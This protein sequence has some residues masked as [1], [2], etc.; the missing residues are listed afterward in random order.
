[1]HILARGGWQQRLRLMA[2]LI[3]FVFVLC[4]LLNHALGV[5]GLG[6]LEA[7]Q[8]WR[9]AF[10][11]YPAVSWLL[12]GAAFVHVSLGIL[13]TARRKTWKIKPWE[14]LQI[15]SGL[16]VPFIIS[17][18]VTHSRI[19]HELFDVNDAYQY[20]LFLIWPGSAWLQLALVLVVWMH[21]CI[22][23][24]FWLRLNNVYRKIFAPVLTFMIAVPVA[25]LSGFVAGGRDARFTVYDDETFQELKQKANWP[26]TE[27]RATLEWT[28]QLIEYT[29]VALIL[30]IVGY[31]LTSYII[32]QMRPRVNVAYNGGPE[33]RA[34]LGSTLLETS[35]LFGVPHASVCGGRARCSTCRVLVETG[36][37]ALA[38]PGPAE[39]DTLRSIGAPENVRLACQIRP[40]KPI[41]VSRLISPKVRP[42]AV[43]DMQEDKMEASGVE[44]SLAVMF[45]D[46][47]R[48]TSISEDRLPYDVVY[49]LNEFFSA[50][51]SA[52][53]AHEGWIDKYLGD[54]LMAVFGRN[55]G[56]RLGCRQALAAARDIDLALDAVNARFSDELPEPLRIGIGI[57]IGPVVLG[58]I[59]HMGSAAM[60]VIGRTVNTAAR[61][62]ALSKD[63]SCQVV[64]STSLARR[65]HLA[66]E[67]Y[68]SQETEIRG[69][70]QPMQVIAIR[71][72]RDIHFTDTE[73]VDA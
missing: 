32:Q 22:G 67:G 66:M 2:G 18:H 43:T 5:F 40:T 69:L 41:V 8:A 14:A 38:A 30:L 34:F 25:A 56:T 4:H 37:E 51:G 57:H 11:R 50:A 19:A 21:G 16:A 54:G 45:L 29:G 31:Y 73:P 17:T 61:L 23:L 63:L 35:R 7:T 12:Y 49:L 15:V 13:K 46:V 27:E 53:E 3:L 9:V 52:I 10:T 47:R 36:A 64:V 20:T 59:G 62:E 48:F 28:D 42:R 6:T 24:H 44:R 70:S 55:S 72:G 58:E 33:V 60:T 26:T 71:Q 1:M 68:A 39:A 65:G